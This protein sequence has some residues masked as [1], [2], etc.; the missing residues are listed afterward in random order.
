MRPSKEIDPKEENNPASGKVKVMAEFIRIADLCLL[1]IWEF[2]QIQGHWVSD[3]SQR[4]QCEVWEATQGNCVEKHVH[5]KKTQILELK[6][7]VQ[8]DITPCFCRWVPRG[9]A[10]WTCHRAFENCALAEGG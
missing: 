9:G 7:C 10:V 5:R 2:G 3:F 6:L 4:Q 8:Y 1:T